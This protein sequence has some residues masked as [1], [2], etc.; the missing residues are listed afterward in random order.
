MLSIHASWARRT[1]LAAQNVTRMIG[2]MISAD[3]GGEKDRAREGVK[4]FLCFAL[5][6]AIA[7][8]FYCRHMG[9]Y[10]DDY[11]YTLG[12]YDWG[13]AK[14]W[15]EALRAISEPVQGRPLNHL[16]RRTLNFITLRGDTLLYA[17]MASW[18]LLSLNATLLYKLARQH[19]GA[20]AALLGGLA[21]LLYPADS[22][23][24]ILMHQSDLLF[25][26][27]LCLLGLH[28]FARGKPWLGWFCGLC[29]LLNYESFFLPLAVAPLIPTQDTQ[30]TARKAWSWK[31]LIL[32]GS[33]FVGLALTV[34]FVRA[35]L[36]E[37]RAGGL[38]AGVGASAAKSL[39][40]LWQGPASCLG[41]FGNAF[42]HAL[43]LK[44]M[45]L[46]LVAL[47]F[48][49]C[50][51]AL[52]YAKTLGSRKQES[53]NPAGRL[54]LVGLLAWSLSYALCIR[55][56]NS[57]P[58]TTLGRLSGVHVAGSIGFALL[59]AALSE[60]IWGRIK[61]RA[62]LLTT[63]AVL[64]AL[65]GILVGHGL[66]VQEKEY[67]RNWDQQG[68][69]WR[70]IMPLIADLRDN[71]PVLVDLEK[72]EALL[73]HTAGFH[74]FATVNY[75][76]VV[77]HRV[78]DFPANW[79][80]KP[81]VFGLWKQCKTEQRG[82]LLQLRT[83]EWFWEGL[84]PELKSGHFVYLRARGQHWERVAG[85]VDILGYVLEARAQDDGVHT[86]KPNKRFQQL[87]GAN[88]SD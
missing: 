53:A 56:D 26:A 79:K 12:C 87:Y 8:F 81:R 82:E 86:I 54:A 58:I 66:W 11:I 17:Q 10:E 74:R 31:R 47:S 70:E 39:Q 63:A 48:I 15:D 19:L 69:F 45:G 55:P 72:A 50:A 78:S 46:A 33:I 27:T 21:Y 41:A 38:G 28:A 71:E 83:P 80:L 85:K 4:V 18:L 73:P 9:L 40:A 30:T 84:W 2:T 22:S 36:G 24:Q 68:K 49:L 3:T 64:S 16:F 61:T 59:V 34:V 13:W 62:R 43:Q 32:H 37:S 60:L 5:F 88:V 23:R 1:D 76:P 75:A 7:H 57:P 14:W 6:G 25:G 65:V 44:G 77:L 67:V 51:G 42:L 35:L 52:L 29:C 20:V